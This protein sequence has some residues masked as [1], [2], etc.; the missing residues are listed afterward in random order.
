MNRPRPTPGAAPSRAATP[1]GRCPLRSLASI[2]AVGLAIGTA[3]GCGG[4]PPA[5]RSAHTSITRSRAQVV[6]REITLRAGDLPEFKAKA[7]A[8]AART[9]AEDVDDLNCARPSKHGASPPQALGARHRQTAGR[10]RRSRQRGSTRRIW[11]SA[12]SDRLSAGSGY[13]ALGAS[14]SV[15]IMSTAGT[16]RL[17]VAEGER[18]R[19]CME[20]V[21]SRAARKGFHD[22]RGVVVKPLSMAVAGA[23]ASVAYQTIVGLRR[24]PLIV[25]M[26]SI[27]FA[28]GQDM[29]TLTTHH[30]SKP[31]PPAME[32]RLLGLLVARARS[33]TR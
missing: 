14:S 2:L 30:S 9:G 4:D 29:V 28:Y 23:D 6:A 12:R 11:A 26:D 5:L 8:P 13:H 24:A 18:Q 21:L 27:V 17:N 1:V 15:S 25:Y 16:A 32:Q 22:I 31:V 7:H 19:A 20:R 33:H 3:I 10:D